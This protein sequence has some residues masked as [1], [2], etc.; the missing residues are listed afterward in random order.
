MTGVTRET[1]EGSVYL[2]FGLC[3]DCGAYVEAPRALGPIGKAR[4]ARGTKQ[5][6]EGAVMIC[7]VPGK[8]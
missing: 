1:A 5:S 2:Q 6:A 4:K 8:R 7:I 3:R